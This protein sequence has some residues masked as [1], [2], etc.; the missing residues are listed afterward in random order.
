MV[1][2]A[3]LLAV[4]A[5]LCSG[6]HYGFLYSNTVEPFTINL[7]RTPIG[8]TTAKV[9]SHYVREPITAVRASAEW[10]SRAIGDAAKNGGLDEIY[11]AD[12]QK[13][14]ILGGAYRRETV[15]VRGTKRPSKE[16]P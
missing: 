3:L 12:I 16:T 5:T 6:C 9:S 1:I 14:S 8:D 2:R 13:I 4:T 10:K 7:E 11:Y 15:L